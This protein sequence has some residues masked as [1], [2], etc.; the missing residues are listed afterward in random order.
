MDEEREE[1]TKTPLEKED[2]L[3][4]SV[5]RVGFVGLQVSVRLSLQIRYLIELRWLFI[6]VATS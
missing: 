3:S 4:S 2:E 5:P 6:R 1:I